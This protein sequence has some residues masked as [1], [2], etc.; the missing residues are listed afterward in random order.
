MGR[1]DDFFAIGGRSLDAMQVVSRLRRELK[2]SI[3]LIDLF[4]TPRLSDL[5]ERLLE[6][7]E[8]Q[9][10]PAIPK[11]QRARIDLTAATDSRP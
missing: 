11:R 4:E 10:A 1:H 5:A 9:A 3:D 8:V 6:R 7:R 2:A